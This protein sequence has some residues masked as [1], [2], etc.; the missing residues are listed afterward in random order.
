[1]PHK[2]VYSPLAQRKP[3]RV[4]TRIAWVECDAFSL[5]VFDSRLKEPTEYIWEVRVLR[6][7]LRRRRP[8]GKEAVL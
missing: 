1:M 3:R 4:W 6:W 7:R 5:T 2:F 8:S